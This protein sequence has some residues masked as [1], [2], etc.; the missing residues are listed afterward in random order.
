MK[1]LTRKEYECLSPVKRS[2]YEKR[3]KKYYGAKR[4]DLFTELWVSIKGTDTTMLY[5]PISGFT[6]VS[7]KDILDA[8]ETAVS[9]LAKDENMTIDEAMIRLYEEVG[10]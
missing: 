1:L 7:T 2:V 10:P 6:Y 3:V 8:N 4:K 5:D 9:I